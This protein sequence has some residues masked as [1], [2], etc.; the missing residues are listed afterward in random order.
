MDGWMRSSGRNFKFLSS[1]SIS[2]TWLTAVVLL[3]EERN[4]VSLEYVFSFGMK[5]IL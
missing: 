4:A 3:V 1:F 2:S 5:V